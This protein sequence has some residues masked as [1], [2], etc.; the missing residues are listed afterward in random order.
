MPPLSLDE[1]LHFAVA[2]AMMGE[3]A[4]V[5]CIDRTVAQ[6]C[7]KKIHGLRMPIEIRRRLT[8]RQWPARKP[9]MMRFEQGI[10]VQP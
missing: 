5:W 10:C 2:G 4:T 6:A 3:K 9:T 8:V 7:R 1:L